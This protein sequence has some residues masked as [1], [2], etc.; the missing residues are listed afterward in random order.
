ME[1]REVEELLAAYSLNALP[2]EEMAQMEAHV[3][4]CPHCASIAAE[5]SQIA[6]R[7]SVV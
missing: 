2:P 1:C 4:L 3:S 6:D 7:K 5:Y